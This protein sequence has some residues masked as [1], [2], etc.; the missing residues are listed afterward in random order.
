MWAATMA[1]NRI[2]K[3]GKRTDFECH[4]MEHQLGV[5]EQTNLKEIAGTVAI[6]PGSY[7]HMMH[8]EIFKIFKECY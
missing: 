7:K 2:I 8:E 4:Q 5:T 1:E 6:V 3:L